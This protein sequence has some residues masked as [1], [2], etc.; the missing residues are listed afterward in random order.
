MSFD[1]SISWSL[2]FE[3]ISSW[4]QW[5]YFYIISY[6]EMEAVLLLSKRP[7]TAS[8]AWLGQCPGE[9][10]TTAA[11]GDITVRRLTSQEQEINIP[12]CSHHCVCWKPGTI[13]C[14][15][16]RLNDAYRLLNLGAIKS[17][18]LNKLH[19]FQCIVKIFCVEFQRV[20]LKLHW[21]SYP[22]IVK[23]TILIQ[24]LK[25]KRSQIYELVYIFEMPPPPPPPHTHTHRH[26]Q[27]LF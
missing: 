26:P 13:S 6:V 2:K 19:N 11:W 17:L 1:I 18:L 4:N 16:G 12:I 10:T 24:C 20:P 21:I 7:M 27:W 5:L 23:D 15:G 8:H 3:W 14:S 9:Q 22:Y 25:C